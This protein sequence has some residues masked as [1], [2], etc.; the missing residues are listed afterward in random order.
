MKE[1]LHIPLPLD[2]LGITEK[3]FFFRKII[4]LHTIKAALFY[5]E[6]DEV[7]ECLDGWTEDEDAGVEAVRPAHVR[8][9]GQFL[10]LKQLIAVTDHLHNTYNTAL[11]PQAKR[12]QPIVSLR[13]KGTSTYITCCR[14]GGT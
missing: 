6:L 2:N 14:L 1:W 12:P 13:L 9:R 10:S 3:G 11:V 7:S 4:N 8:R 5:G